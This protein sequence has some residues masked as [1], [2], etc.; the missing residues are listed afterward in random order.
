MDSIT[1]SLLSS[2]QKLAKW[3]DAVANQSCISNPVLFNPMNLSNVALAYLSLG[4]IS[5]NNHYHRKGSASLRRILYLQ[6]VDGSWNEIYPR[7]NVKSTLATAFV[8]YNLLRS[9]N[10]VDKELAIHIKNSVM[11]ASRYVGSKELA[12]GYF[13]KSETNSNDIVNVN[14]LCSLYFLYLHNYTDA[15]NFFETSLRTVKRVI[16]SQLNSGAF[17]YYTI[18][19]LYLTPIHYHA[20]M[21]RLLAEYHSL[22]RD[23]QVLASLKKAISWLIDKFDEQGKIRWR[24]DVGAWVYRSFPSYGQALY[25][26]LYI[27]KL[28]EQ[29]QIQTQRIFNHI[30]RSQLQEGPF[31]ITD[32]DKNLKNICIDV[33]NSIK[34]I[35]HCDFRAAFSLIKR[36]FKNSVPNIHEKVTGNIQL[37]EALTSSQELFQSN[38]FL[39]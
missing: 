36:S 1:S 38:T 6:N 31:P 27:S 12:P 33:E 11:R 19:K 8:G 5:K 21:T 29:F 26:L 35:S 15:Q 2:I 30:I 23:E 39:T 17:P 4:E 22:T 28:E 32:N 14:M 16:K 37:L 25:S 9:I 20:F 13:L 3:L 18:H 34:L 7:I 10:F 24:G